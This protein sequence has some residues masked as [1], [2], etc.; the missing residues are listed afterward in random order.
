M[1]RNGL[2]FSLVCLG[3]LA[4]AR[5]EL[6]NSLALKPDQPEIREALAIIDAA[7]RAPRR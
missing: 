2:G 1:S 4:E 7:P 6:S 5:R 3:R